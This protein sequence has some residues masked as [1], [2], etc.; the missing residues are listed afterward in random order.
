MKRGTWDEFYLGLACHWA[1]HRSKDPSTKCGAIIVR[2]DRTQA[3][4]G[5]NGFPRGVDDSP[6][7]YDDRTAKYARVVHAEVNA[8]LNSK[9]PSL[10][11]YTIYVWPF[12]TCERCAANIIQVGIT[13]VVT[14]PATTSQ[15]ERWGDSFKIAMEMYAQAG[16]TVDVIG[17]ATCAKTPAEA[18]GRGARAGAGKGAGAL[19]N[20]DWENHG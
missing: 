2:P 11:G 19:I 13:R 8:I 15:I 14:P 18:V 3:G 7:L 17:A 16:V 1:L 10:Q 4:A 5:Y 6:E 20:S 9:D 12:M